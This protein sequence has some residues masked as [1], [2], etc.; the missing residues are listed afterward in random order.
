M[1]WGS[2]GMLTELDADREVVWQGELPL[3]QVVG[4]TS[5]VQVP[6]QPVP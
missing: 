3:G 2:L 6:G 5:D 4:F 1:S